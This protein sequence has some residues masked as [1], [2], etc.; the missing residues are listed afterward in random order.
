MHLNGR[1]SSATARGGC[2]WDRRSIV[3]AIVALGSVSVMLP[4]HAASGVEAGWWTAVPVVASPDAPADGLFVQGG[5]ASDGAVAYAAVAYSLAP[6]ESPVSLRLSVLKGSAST[7]NTTLAVCPLV[8]SFTP[9]QGGPMEEAPAFDCATRTTAA[10]SADGTTYTFDVASLSGSSSLALAILPTAP[11]DRVVLERPNADSLAADTAS[12]ASALPEQPTSST[13][14]SSDPAAPA[15]VPEV[16]VFDVILPS[17]VDTT[18]PSAA[19]IE[20]PSEVATASP[21]AIAGQLNEADRGG[22]ALPALLFMTLA[23]AAAALWLFAGRTRVSPNMDSEVGRG[24]EA[25]DQIETH[26]LV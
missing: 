4:A 8:E 25:V 5:P 9:K 14:P 3:A 2:R 11:T 1:V 6:G 21:S 15:A 13:E 12:V 19:P 7:P 24:G 16:D 23:L 17:L 18:P 22:S 20:T 10:L 26:Q